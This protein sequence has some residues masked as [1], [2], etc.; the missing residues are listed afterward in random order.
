MYYRGVCYR[1]ARK[2]HGGDRRSQAAAASREGDLPLKTADLL[3]RRWNISGW[4]VKRCLKFADAL[5][6]LMAA[7]DRLK[8]LPGR[9]GSRVYN[10]VARRDSRYKAPAIE[11]LSEAPPEVQREG[12][13][14][15]L[16]GRAILGEP[17][18][19]P[20]DRVRV[21]LFKTDLEKS[22]R[23][24]RQALPGELLERL[25]EALDRLYSRDGPKRR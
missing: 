4:Q 15:I 1:Q 22:A 14:A 21:I 25:R 18:A 8:G 9:A 17:R 2:S 6:A 7:A 12:I 11:E 13:E 5:E 10:A 19:A 3:G 23:R 20:T 24:L 16:A